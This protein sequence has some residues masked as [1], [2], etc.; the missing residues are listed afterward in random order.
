MANTETIFSGS[1]MV[2]T[3]HQ[4]GGVMS[5][6]FLINTVNANT[7]SSTNNKKGG[8]LISTLKNLAVPAVLF[9][10]ASNIE[11][12]TVDE[13]DAGVIKDSTYDELI[14]DVEHNNKKKSKTSSKS[15]TRRKRKS[16]AKKSRKKRS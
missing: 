14:R 12:L 11:K 9:Y 8:G 16:S 4:N 7:E 13:K 3:T 2:L 5:G 6:G 15:K 10:A 1:D